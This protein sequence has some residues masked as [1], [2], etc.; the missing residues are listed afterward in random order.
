MEILGLQSFDSLKKFGVGE[1]I[2]L[3]LEKI[4]KTLK[5]KK[6]NNV[7]FDITLMRGF[8]YYTGIVFEFFDT[9]PENNRSLF[10]GGRFDDLLDIFG[11]EKIPAIGF[12]M[13][14]V[15]ARDFLEIRGILPEEKTKTDIAVLLLDKEFYQVASKIV[16]ELRKE[17][18]VEFDFSYRKL[19]KQIKS[20]D[21]KGIENILTI[22][23]NEIKENKFTLKNILS[24]EKKE[25]LSVEEIIS[26]LK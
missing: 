10:G 18:N 25:N 21:K 6:I 20:A 13:G 19:E 11:Q 4:Q 8:D 12:G 24:G 5:S 1:N 14:D 16:S 22:G 23:E 2:I 9:H 7:V 3:D 17:L 26:E 15:T